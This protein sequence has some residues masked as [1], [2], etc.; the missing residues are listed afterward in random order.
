MVYLDCNLPCANAEGR[1]EELMQ[2][3]NTGFV[4][5]DFLIAWRSTGMGEPN[6][7]LLLTINQLVEVVNTNPVN[8][9]I[10]II[11]SARIV[12]LQK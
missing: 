6:P 1:E 9:K 7:V 11:V 3:V 4:S 12:F 2:E 5:P 8:E 10:A